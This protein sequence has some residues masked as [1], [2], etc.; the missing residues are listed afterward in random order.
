MVPLKVLALHITASH[1]EDIISTGPEIKSIRSKKQIEGLMTADL[2]Q[3][4]G[5]GGSRGG[6]QNER[7]VLLF[8]FNTIL[9]HKITL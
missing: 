6:V 2:T 4:G 1:T 7:R 8:L 3:F 5:G 9:K